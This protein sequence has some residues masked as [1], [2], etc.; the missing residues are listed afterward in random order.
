MEK[1]QKQVSYIKSTNVRDF[2][3]QSLLFNTW[4]LILPGNFKTFIRSNFFTPHC[5]ALT[6]QQMKLMER[7]K[8][9]TVSY[10]GKKIKI[11]K[12]GEGPSILFVHGWNGRGVQFQY[13]FDEIIQRNMSVIFFDGPAHGASDGKQTNYL[14]MS[15]V[16]DVVLADPIS[17]NVRGIVSHSIGSSISINHLSRSQ[18]N[19]PL[20][21]IAPALRLMELLYAS[22]EMHSVPSKT[23]ESLV[24]EVEAKFNLNLSTQNPIDLIKKL[25]NNM[26]ILHDALDQI[27]PIEPSLEIESQMSNVELQTTEG[28]GHSGI[29]KNA[30]IIESVTGF[31][32]DQMNTEIDKTLVNGP[33]AS[34]L[35]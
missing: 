6:P 16:L 25:N 13:F 18:R 8:E 14:E 1:N 17:Q 2:K 12:L 30:E 4:Q 7:A 3:F 35:G 9:T 22:F 26:L 19:V 20:V 15:R 5:K 34:V 31:L 24:Q 11:W 29:L 32:M 21:L 23:Y 28:L 33:Q 27:T 10:E